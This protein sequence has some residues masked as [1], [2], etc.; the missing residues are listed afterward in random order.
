MRQKYGQNFLVNKGVIDK[1]LSA[2]AANMQPQTVE[3][4]AGKGAL[5]G[6]L[7]LLDKDLKVIEIDPLMAQY[8]AQ[9]LNPAPQVT[10]T[11]FLGYDLA[12]L[13]EKQTLF[14]SNLPYID[15]FGILDKVLDYKYFAAAVFMFQREQAQKI[16]AR[17][18]DEK[19][20]YY[21]VMSQARA[22]A[23]SVMRV[24]PG[25]FNP[26]PKV[27]SE[28]LLFKSRY[29]PHGVSLKLKTVAK[30]AFAYKRKSIF[31]SLHAAGLAVTEETLKRAGI[32]PPMRAQ[33]VPV[34]NFI[35]LADLA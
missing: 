14:V 13:E 11:D 1:I 18:G 35:R 3:I 23:R 20:S 2:A 34:D 22:Q 29:L 32:L 7:L 12:G 33:D 5:T 25:S 21:S 27:E 17:P 26:P 8:L 6:G 4:G 16:L 28:V 31:N 9:N 15:A 19:Y 30:A 24:S 10:I